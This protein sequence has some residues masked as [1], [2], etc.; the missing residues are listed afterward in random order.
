MTMT[1]QQVADE[2]RGAES[3]L[4]LHGDELADAI[5]AHIAAM[6]EPVAFMCDVSP[7]VG[8]HPTRM[9]SLQPFLNQHGQRVVQIPLYTA[10][11]IDMDAVREVMGEM[12]DSKYFDRNGWIQDWADRLEAALAGGGK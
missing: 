8:Q 10:P 12:R 6:G 1:L 2:L 5:D 7:V 4:Y 3:D 9:L 11:P